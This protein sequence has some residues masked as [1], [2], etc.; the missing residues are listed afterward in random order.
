MSAMSFRIARPA[1]CCRQGLSL[2]TALLGL[3][4][5]LLAGCASPVPLIIRTPAAGDPGL[6]AVRAD[7]RAYHGQTV[8]WGGVII[9]TENHPQLTRLTILGRQLDSDGQPRQS[10]ASQGRFIALIHGFLDPA[11]YSDGRLI[12]VQGSVQGEETRKVDQFPYVYPVV[13]VRN[14]Y[15][16][17][18]PQPEPR[19]PY[20]DDPFWYNTWYPYYGPYWPHRW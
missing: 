11:I 20:W 6:A 18:L 10:D 3:L 1:P 9:A 4:A 7:P 8:R 17:P 14:Y 19:D 15:L 12:T 13:D 2:R 16:W 5:L